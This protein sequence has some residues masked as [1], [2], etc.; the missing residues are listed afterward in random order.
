MLYSTGYDIL[1]RCTVPKPTVLIY[2]EGGVI[3]YSITSA[4]SQ[5]EYDTIKT[6]LEIRTIII[7]R[8]RD[9]LSVLGSYCRR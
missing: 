1:H 5:V 7:I 8:S 4:R 6:T 3:A 9:T 2:S